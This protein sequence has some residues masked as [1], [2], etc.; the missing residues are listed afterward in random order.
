ML[1]T[2]Q[3]RI[4]L[5][6]LLLLLTGVADYVVSFEISTAIFYMIP[7]IVFSYQH[8]LRLSYSVLFAI[9]AWLVWME[10]DYLTHP[11]SEQRYLVINWFFR[12]ALFVAT[13]IVANRF[14][15]EKTQR[16]IISEQKAALEKINQDLNRLLGVAAHDIRNPVGS[17][18]TMA[19]L[20]LEEKAI[21]QEIKELVGM[22]QIS[23]KNSL[24]IL[25]DTLNISQIE[26]GTIR[27]NIATHDYI[28]F[29][30]ECI[31]LN[32][33]LAGRK[34]QTIRLDSSI[35]WIQTA[36][37][38]SRISQAV[39]NLLTN[40]IKY[41]ENGTEIIVRVSFFDKSKTQLLTEVIDKGLGIDK[42]Y[43]KILFNPFSTTSNKPTGNESKS[44]LGLA[45]V[46]KVVEL[47]KGE[48]GFRSEKGKGS[49]FYFTLPVNHPAHH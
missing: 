17:I 32:N 10:M 46:K 16:K 20:L 48:V 13:A 7:I 18:Q 40:A 8:T 42:E 45:I 30:K 14:F 1:K 24:Q 28:Q 47:H 6:A 11:Y 35:E 27:L 41:S 9:L 49:D 21:T 31:E 37:D 34:N 22:I 23:A 26:S 5:S 3:Q 4:I 43:H 29:I 39:T 38:K 19:E 36:F 12:A 33:H 25:N 15:R 2:V 44:G